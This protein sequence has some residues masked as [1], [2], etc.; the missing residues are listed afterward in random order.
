MRQ[1][2]ILLA[3]AAPASARQTSLTPE[4]DALVMQGV[5]SIYRMDFDAADEAA[6]KAMALNP[7]Y[8][9]AFLG[10]AATDFIRYVYGPAQSDD[11]LVVSFEKKVDI[12]NAVAERWLAAHPN[13]AEALL[14]L[15]SG[16]GIR[17]RLALE[18][19]QYLNGFR[20]GSR[21]M[22]YIRA[23]LV[24]DPE[25]Y[26]SYLGLGM[27]DYYVATIPRFAGW[28]AK[29]MLGGDRARGLRELR[30]AAEKG[31]FAR[32]AAQLILVEIDTTDAF[33][34]RD[35][36]DAVRLMR[37]IVKKY[38]ESSML[39]SAYIVAL[40]EDKE[41]DEGLREA[42]EYTARVR[43]GRYPAVNMSIAR[44]MTGTL[45]WAEGSKDEALAEFLA[46]TGDAPPTRWSVWNEIRA[47]QLLDALGRRDE[48]L[49]AY[50]SAYAEPD[51]WDFK[52]I[53]KACLA[54]PCAGPSYPGLF[55]PD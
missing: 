48:A 43:S 50:K 25:I 52:A 54:K 19:H 26:D 44:A 29:I 34:A 7:D 31:H 46:G 24:A 14:V 3:L 35:P 10:A 4:M 13:D 5:D 42:R 38:P 27:F 36:A 9:H 30:L 47:G 28:L 15:G 55:S 45:L 33:G 12:A 32:V 20:Y 2:L 11:R 51:K 23:S 6:R 21:S 41:Y 53:V 8:P 17:A 22:K 1:I 18:R 49:L 40:Y 37:G 16:Y 39:Q